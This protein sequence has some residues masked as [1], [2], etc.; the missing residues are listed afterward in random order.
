MAI[1]TLRPA[2]GADEADAVR[3]VL[4]SRWLGMGNLTQE[5]E[6]RLAGLVGTRHVVAVSSGTAALH[7]ALVTLGVSPGEEVVVPSLTF[8]GCAQAVVAAGATPVF[9][10]VRPESVTIDAEDAARRITPR[11][12]AILAVDYAGF[13]CEEIDAVVELARGHDLL[14]VHDGAHAFGSASKGR[15]VGSLGDAT[16]FSFDP[17]K[18][19]TCGEGGAVA[20]DDDELAERLRTFRNL[21]IP[22]GAWARRAA[23]RWEYGASEIGF[24]YMLPDLN[25]AIGLVQLDSLD[26]RRERKRALLRGYRQALGDVQGLELLP[27]DVDSSFPFLC[28]ARVEDGRRNELIEWLR[29]DGIAAGVHFVPIHLQPAFAG[30]SLSVT[31][32]VYA[33]LVSLPFYDELTDAD[34]E[35]VAHSV[36]GFFANE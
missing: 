35:R 17:V 10:E 33:R 18:N 27:G 5:F 7:A 22:E 16:C 15:P 6:S 32:D 12:R 24:R 8:V 19:V 34:V 28:V 3:R 11:T 29:L 25:A 1:P 2:V 14:V 30:A 21:G 9:C 36:R 20:T 31:E 23:G 13:I 26:E 4:E